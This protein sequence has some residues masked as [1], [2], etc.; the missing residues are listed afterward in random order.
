MLREHRDACNRSPGASRLVLLVFLGPLR[1]SFLNRKGFVFLFKAC[2]F[3][4]G[5]LH[6][7][8]PDTGIVAKKLFD[9]FLE[10]CL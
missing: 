2:I 5:E 1:I 6:T 7:H 3:G 8:V 9:E 10:R 4:E